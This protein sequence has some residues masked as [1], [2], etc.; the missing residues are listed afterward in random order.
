MHYDA[1]TLACMAHEL[2]RN[3]VGGRVQ[4]VVLPD[5]DS[6]GMEIYAQRVRHNLLIAVN[7]RNAFVY[8]PSQKARRGVEKETPLLLLLRKYV[9]NATLTAA[10]LPDPTERAMRLEFE[11][12]Q[13]GNTALVVELIGRRANA[14]LLNPADRILECVHRLPGN[15]SG[16]RD[17]MPGRLYTPPAAQPKLSP[18]D[19]G[20]PDYYARLATAI[21]RPGKLWKA[22]VDGFAGVGPTQGRELAWRVSGS[23]D[24]DSR[25]GLQRDAQGEEDTQFDA[26]PLRL[27]VIQ[28]LQALWTPAF[29]PPESDSLVDAGWEPGIF[30]EAGK[31]IGFAPYAVHFRGEFRPCAS[32]SEAIE[33]YLTASALQDAR[34]AAP[35]AGAIDP[36]AGLRNQ[37]QAQLNKA[38]RRVERQL[39][40]LAKDEPAPGASELL[41]AQAEWLLALHSQI[42]PG[43]QTL[44]IELGI[45]AGV[46]GVESDGMLRIPLREDKTP[47][48]QAQQMFKQA[49]KLGRAAAF[50]PKRRAQL[51]TELEFLHQLENDLT[52]AENQPEIATVEQELFATRLLPPP[53][54][55]RPRVPSTSE[56]LRFL[57]EQG[58]EIVAGR[59]ARQ[60]E[61]V[62]FK[63][64]QAEDSW[65]HAR[66]VPGSHVVIRTG[67]QEPDPQTLEQA[68]QIA[69]YYSRA[70][71]ERAAPVIV[72]RRKHIGRAPGGRKGQVTVREEQTLTVRAELPQDLQPIA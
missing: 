55:A 64:A 69:A 70:R 8:C 34:P 63:I 1:L 44:E 67:G 19:D 59:N 10:Y 15:E 2:R 37:V 45:D 28:S 61:L 47:V 52:L 60:N 23:V 25:A 20:E 7:P 29:Q 57:T 14:L 3:L 56:P 27:G 39:A 6:I 42:A 65:L 33:L 30:S 50:I 58:Y 9:R 66:G 4:Q 24:T 41:R 31:P 22:L 12:A 36:Y 71:G 72:T 43:A 13:H 16:G 17:L 68:A 40:G 49:G 32:L 38:R 26:A 21:D 62:T 51:Q 46:P 54:K 5:A 18:L 35:H 53:K 48:E 11:H